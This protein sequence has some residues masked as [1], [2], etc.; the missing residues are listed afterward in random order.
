M[1]LHVGCGK[2]YLA[3][4]VN[5]DIDTNVKADYH[6]PAN[7]LP[8]IRDSSVEVVMAVHLFEHLYLWEVPQALAEWHRVLQPGGRLVL[9]MP[10]I[11]KAAKNLLE[12]KGDQQSMWALYGDPGQ[13][14]PHNSHRWGWHPESLK[15]I[16]AENGFNNFQEEPTQYHRAGKAHRD[17]RVVAKKV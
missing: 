9:E 6:A 17:M 2:R 4:W 11:M 7:S 10:D 16:L 14:N 8:L 5:V 1:K 15:G 3:G 12:G 13:C